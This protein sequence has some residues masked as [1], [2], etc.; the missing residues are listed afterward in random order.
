MRIVIANRDHACEIL[1]IQ[2]KFTGDMLRKAY[3]RQALKYHPDK[4]GG[5][6]EKFQEIRQAFDYLNDTDEEDINNDSSFKIESILKKCI[7]FFSPETDLDDKFINT[8]LKN[9]LINCENISVEIFKNLTFE[10]ATTLYKYFYQYNEVFQLSPEV[11]YKMKQI[12]KEKAESTNILVLK[13]TID[14]LLNNKIYKLE[15]QEHDYYIPLWHKRF[16]INDILVLNEYELSD[17][18][19]IKDNNDIWIY[20]EIPLHTLFHDGDCEIFMGSKA[21]KIQADTLKI[22]QTGKIQKKNLSA[23]WNSVSLMYCMMKMQ[24]SISCSIWRTVMCL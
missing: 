11:L 19:I 8:S 10:K 13:S 21:I 18:I 9:I 3:L 17:N 5:N 2:P 20:K 14:D 7:G 24:T 1:G 23:F 16:N 12:I 15:H 22:T 6:K 4:P